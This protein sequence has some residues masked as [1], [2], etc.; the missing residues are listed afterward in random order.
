[1]D[2]NVVERKIQQ[3]FTLVKRYVAED[4]EMTKR[5]SDLEATNSNLL[6]MQGVDVR[7][8]DIRSV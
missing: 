2:V 7:F 1:M 6:I 5:K 3:I 4:V 8:V